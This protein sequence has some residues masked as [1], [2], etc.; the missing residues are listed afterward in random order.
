MI[1]TSQCHRGQN[2]TATELF[3]KADI[4]I[5]ART[6]STGDVTSGR[7][8]TAKNPGAS[9]PSIDQA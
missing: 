6:A 3:P 8:S 4:H 2:V 9:L 7:C 5:G 1:F